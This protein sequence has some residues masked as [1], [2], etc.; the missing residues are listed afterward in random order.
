MVRQDDPSSDVV[1]DDDPP[2]SSAEDG[3]SVSDRTTAAPSPLS[4][5]SATTTK[6]CDNECIMEE[7]SNNNNNWSSDPV[8]MPYD[9]AVCFRRMD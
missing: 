4:L 1:V 8:P 5:G 2:N 6:H 9:E 3:L 7:T